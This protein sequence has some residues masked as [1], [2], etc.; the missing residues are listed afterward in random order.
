MGSD[1]LRSAVAACLN[2]VPPVHMDE[3]RNPRAGATGLNRLSRLL[4]A[5][6]RAIDAPAV[7]RHGTRIATAI[8]RACFWLAC[9]HHFGTE[10]LLFVAAAWSFILGVKDLTFARVR[11]ANM[12]DPLKRRAAIAKSVGLEIGLLV[13]RL[14]LVAAVGGILLAFN[15]TVAAL[16]TA[17]MVCV[18]FW[19]R[20]TMVT[21]ARVYGV[22]PLLRYATLLSSLSGLV[23]IVLFARRGWDPVAAAT[24]ALIIREAVTFVGCGAVAA[25]G[26]LSRNAREGQPKE[27]DEDEDEAGGALPLIGADG[28]EIRSTF[29]IFIAD[30]VVYSWWR[31]VQF[32][33]RV[34]AGGLLGPL[35]NIGTR[36]FF[37]YQRPGGFGQSKARPSPGRMVLIGGALAAAAVVVAVVAHRSGLLHAVGIVAA[38]FALRIVG[39][40]LNLL[41][42][43]HFRPLI[44]TSEK[45]RPGDLLFPRRALNRMA[46]G[47][48]ADGGPPPA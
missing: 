3:A 22:A 39:L 27:D 32:G 43:R 25:S 8:F 34:L 26:M 44:T 37:T 4:P 24:S 30:N 40:G 13:L 48:P 11:L 9:F 45:I 19:A 21:L 18:L 47:S 16:V 5:N 12:A 31:I 7:A 1:E 46:P 20:E 35:G 15:Q 29:K 10:A 36:I 6:R 23:L 41:L 14:A 42:W 38:A 28:K 17:L 33:T 2:F